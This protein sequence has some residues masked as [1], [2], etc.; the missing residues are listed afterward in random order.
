MVRAP[1]GVGVS[2]PTPF[3]FR[4]AMSH[5]T[6]AGS[7]PGKCMLPMF[8]ISSVPKYY[9]KGAKIYIFGFS[10]SLTIY[11]VVYNILGLYSVQQLA[12]ST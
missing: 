9:A 7:I 3:N 2:M 12:T 5:L 1:S 10:N 11:S 6:S 8:V 4:L